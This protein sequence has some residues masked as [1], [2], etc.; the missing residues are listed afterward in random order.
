MHFTDTLT[1]WP[2]MWH[3][4]H[5]ERQF[6]LR[7]LVELFPH[8]ECLGD[9]LALLDPLG[10]VVA[11]TNDPDKGWRML[12]CIGRENGAFH[13]WMLHFMFTSRVLTCTRCVSRWG[14]WLWSRPRCSWRCPSRTWRTGLFSPP[15][16]SVGSWWCIQGLAGWS[17]RR[18]SH[19]LRTCWKHRRHGHR[20][21]SWPCC[22]CLPYPLAKWLRCIQML[23]LLNKGDCFW[24][25]KS[26]FTFLRLN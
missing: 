12:I 7:V 2:V 16:G 23:V 9:H 1:H 3:G 5:A 15:W 4:V 17:E 13:F 8:G 26:G 21:V 22:M 18:L 10:F 6:L 24:A 11:T 19:W 20:S 25:G 14:W